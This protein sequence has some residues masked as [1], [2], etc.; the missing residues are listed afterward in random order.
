MGDFW[1][2]ALI[3]EAFENEKARHRRGAVV[4]SGLALCGAPDQ[5]EVKHRVI[6]RFKRNPDANLIGTKFQSLKS[7]WIRSPGFSIAY[8]RSCE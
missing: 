3:V 6:A 2:P 8:F 5:R 7:D 4:F 1:H